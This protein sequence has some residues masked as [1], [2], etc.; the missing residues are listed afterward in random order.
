MPLERLLVMT[1]VSALDWRRVQNWL[2]EHDVE[3]CREDALDVW[4]VRIRPDPAASEALYW[5]R[6][7]W[8]DGYWHARV[9]WEDGA[10]WLERGEDGRAMPL[11]RFHD[12]F[13]DFASDALTGE[14]DEDE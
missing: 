12:I 8:R 11:S 14:E 2:A 9:T 6:D 3:S 4:D 13:L 1:D 7:G 5:G 10:V